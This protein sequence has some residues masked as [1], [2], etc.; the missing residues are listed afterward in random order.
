MRRIIYTCEWSD[1]SDRDRAIEGSAAQCAAKAR[2][3]S[4]RHGVAYVVR[5][6]KQ[7]EDDDLPLF[8]DLAQDVYENGKFAF[9]ETVE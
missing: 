6:R 2:E 4:A 5:R 7:T 8:E 3:M 1:G 9:A